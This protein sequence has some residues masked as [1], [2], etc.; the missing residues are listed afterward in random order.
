MFD[1]GGVI[2]TSP[3]DAFEQYERRN[4]LPEGC[5]R[6]INATNPDTNAWSRLEKGEIPFDR[7]CEIFE[8]EAAEAGHRVDAREVMAGLR[9]TIRPEMVEVVRDCARRFTTACLTNNFTVQDAPER[10]DMG[11]VLSLFDLVLESRTLGIRKPDRRFYEVACESL[12][13]EPAEVVFLDDLGVNLKPARLL[14]M[15]TIKVV[16][17][18]QAIAELYAVLDGPPP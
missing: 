1:L 15:T 16:E 13:V 12:G 11:E 2:T 18:G 8:L 6:R 5:L 10:P 14:G 7:F 17:P 4:G 9:G 3:F